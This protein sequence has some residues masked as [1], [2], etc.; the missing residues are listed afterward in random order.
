MIDRRSVLYRGTVSVLLLGCGVPSRANRFAR[1]PYPHLILQDLAWSMAEPMPATPA[2]LMQALDEYARSIDRT[3][4]K[5][6]LQRRF[7]G[8]AL[9]IR[10]SYAVEPS[11]GK[12]KDI[13]RMVAVRHA[14]PPTYLDI[15]FQ[16]HRESHALLVDQDHH[17]FEGLLLEEPDGGKGV[18]RYALMQGS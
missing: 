6:E 17:Y 18:P 16:L 7:P 12:W 11:P 9:D 1:H 13:G 2:A 5:T 10:F 8:R 4:D 3:L 15:L 14:S